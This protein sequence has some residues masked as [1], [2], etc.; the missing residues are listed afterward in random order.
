MVEGAARLLDQGTQCLHC[1]LQLSNFYHLACEYATWNSKKAAHCPSWREFRVM[2]LS[3]QDCAHS[4]PW[5]NGMS[6]KFHTLL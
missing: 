3:V 6:T 1:S 2:A 5:L 4:F